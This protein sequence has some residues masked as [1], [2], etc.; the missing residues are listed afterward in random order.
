MPSH[1]AEII[2]GIPVILRDSVMYSFQPGFPPSSQV[3]LGS[4]DSATKKATWTESDA[5]VSWLA[6]Y[7]ETLAP[8]SRK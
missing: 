7:R 2:D 4:Y 6:S 8:R 3:V 1:G 5:R